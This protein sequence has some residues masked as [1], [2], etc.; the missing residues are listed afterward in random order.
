MALGAATRQVELT[1]DLDA[2]N[3]NALEDGGNVFHS[4]NGALNFRVSACE[5]WLKGP[6]APVL[7]SFAEVTSD[8]TVTAS[9]TTLIYLDQDGLLTK[10]DVLT[11]FPASSVPLATVTSDGATITAIANARARI[12]MPGSVDGRLWR[13]GRYYANKREAPAST[14]TLA[15]DTLYGIPFDI[16]GDTPIDR[17]AFEVTTLDAGISIRL[18]LYAESLTVRGEPGVL[19]EDLGVIS[20]GSTGIKTGTVS[21]TRRLGPG[22]YFVALIAGSAVVA[23]RAYLTGTS[24]ELGWPGGAADFQA[25][26]L[27]TVWRGATGGN[28]E[29]SAL[30]DP[31]PAT[32]TADL[33]TAYPA[34]IF[35]AA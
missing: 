18:G 9:K 24:A 13:T 10:S 4:P 28:D 31:F 25:A 23:F 29:A 34:A 5:V 6:G 26:S 35:R 2:A 32:P 17:I 12:E 30:P 3:L 22:R 20:A 16:H 7:F 19:L 15:A 1:T 33:S 27:N 8:Q 11:A 14:V 21:P